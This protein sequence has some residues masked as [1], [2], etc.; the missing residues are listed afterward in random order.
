CTGNANCVDGFCCEDDCFAGSTN[1]CMSCGLSAK[2]G[3]CS[4]LV[5]DALCGDGADMNGC[6][7]QDLCDASGDCTKLNHAADTVDCGSAPGVCEKQDKCDGNG[8]C[9]DLGNADLGTNCGNGPA[10]NGCSAQDTCDANMGNCLDNH[11]AEGLN[12]ATP[13]NCAMGCCDGAAACDTGNCNDGES[14]DDD[15]DCVNTC[16]GSMIATDICETL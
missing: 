4:A 2:K 6:S 10:A 12:A 7:G 11:I 13:A 1:D 15:A 8:T 5:E 9:P 14:C 16:S 3:L